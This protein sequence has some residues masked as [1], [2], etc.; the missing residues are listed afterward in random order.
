MI[1]TL[2]M[3]SLNLCPSWAKFRVILQLA[4][5]RGAIRKAFHSNAAHVLGARGSAFSTAEVNHPALG[6]GNVKCS[7]K[8][9][10]PLRT[11]YCS[12]LSGWYPGQQACAPGFRDA[13]PPVGSHGSI[14]ASVGETGYGVFEA[15]PASRNFLQ[16]KLVA[17]LRGKEM[18]WFLLRET[19]K[20]CQG[21]FLLC[22]PRRSLP[23]I[24]E[25]QAI[26]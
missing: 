16:Q 26:V 14:C 5:M 6:W 8:Q 24:N 1:N 11:P 23:R 2:V 4:A 19:S 20:L 12:V 17:V 22:L 18:A 21:P 7:T 15:G 25:H 10:S 9:Y 13:Y 3:F